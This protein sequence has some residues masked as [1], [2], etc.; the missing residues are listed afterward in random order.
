ML[1]MVVERFRNQDGGAVYARLRERGRMM[2]D[3]VEYL[4]SWVEP[5]L[6]RC[7]QLMTCTDPALLQVWASSWDDLV[8]FDFVPVVPGREMAARFT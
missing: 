2:P 1:Y 8:E 3:G 4:D 7:F 5:D 6:N